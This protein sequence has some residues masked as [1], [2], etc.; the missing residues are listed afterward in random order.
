MLCLKS[1]GE[2][3]M[4]DIDNLEKENMIQELE[5]VVEQ[6]IKAPSSMLT[7]LKFKNIIENL[8]F[9]VVSDEKLSELTEKVKE[10]APSKAFL[11][12]KYSTEQALYMQKR[13]ESS[14]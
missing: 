4:K 9:G 6:L 12:L 11:L 5:E 2:R 7:V 10:V 3:K 1:K 14:L 8:P 13:D